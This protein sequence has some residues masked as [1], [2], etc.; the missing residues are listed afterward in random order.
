MDDNRVLLTVAEASIR[1]A[2]GRSLVYQLVMSGALRS[3]KCG[4]AR[5]IPVSALDEFIDCQ[6]RE[7]Q[8]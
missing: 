6:M 5:R 3:I 8:E 7:G 2:L 4:R 1:L